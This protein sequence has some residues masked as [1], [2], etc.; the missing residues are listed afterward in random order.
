MQKTIP[1]TPFSFFLFTSRPHTKSAVVAL[2]MVL[3]ASV[4]SDYL[5]VVLRNLTDSLATRPVDTVGVWKYAVLYPAIYILSQTV[6]RVSGFSGMYWFMGIRATGF[7]VLYEYTAR[8]SKSYF[9]DRFAG[10]LVTNIS[11]AVENSESFFQRVLWVFLPQIISLCVF[12]YVTAVSDWRLG[13]IIAVWTVVFV[14]I[15]YLFVKRLQASAY[16]ANELRSVVKG[17]MVDSLSNI[18]VVHEYAHLSG[19]SSYIARSV[20]DQRLAGLRNWREGEWVLVINGVLI[21]AFIG[22]ML[23]TSLYLLGQGII[24][25][26]VV[27]MVIAI[28]SDLASS[29]FFIGNEMIEAGKEYSGIKEGLF[30]VTYKHNIKDIPEAQPLLVSTGMIEF[31]NVSFNYGSSQIFCGLSVEIKPGQKV[32][33]VGRSGAGK[34]TFVS[35]LLRHYDVVGGAIR[36]DGQ[37]ISQ[38]TLES[39]RRNIAYVPQDTS[40]FHRTIRENIQYGN[41]DAKIEDIERVAD[42]ARAH[43]FIVK[44]KDGYETLVGERGV[45]LSGGQRQRI[46][47]ARAFMKDAPILILDEATSSLDS[48]SEREVQKALATLM[49]G[50]TVI[51]IAHR[52]S[53]LK[54]MDRIILIEDGAIIEDGAPNIL[55]KNRDGA[56]RSLWDHQVSGFIV[57][58]ELDTTAG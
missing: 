40:L 35:L 51:A 1:K 20:H 13:M 33:L 37:A 12:M 11:N 10:S 55:L 19:E 52:L 53:T 5:V 48:E 9:Q 54:E 50:R 23:W 45:R 38:V 6:W 36:I 58:E 49:K 14:G 17:R 8:H 2:I 30:E 21:A 39:L 25:L 34:S 57:D 41:P 16:R 29:L 24:T 42:L 43:G 7:N 26:G 47:L 3:I 56:F 31:D 4:A 22:G 28:V 46:A 27:V 32:G 18:S 15:N 44:L